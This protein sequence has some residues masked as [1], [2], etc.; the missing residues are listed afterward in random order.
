MLINFN[1][2]SDGSKPQYTQLVKKNS[3]FGPTF[4]D[5]QLSDSIFSD[6]QLS[7]SICDKNCDIQ[8]QN[9]LNF[10]IHN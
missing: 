4:S 7:D 8:I 1:F 5:F 9:S 3:A 6:F 10:N 2:V